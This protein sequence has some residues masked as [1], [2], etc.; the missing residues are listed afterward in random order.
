ME[1][2]RTQTG[3]RFFSIEQED[4]DFDY[5]VISDEYY[6]DR[7]YILFEPGHIHNII[8]PIEEGAKQLSGKVKNPQFLITLIPSKQETKL[9]KYMADNLEG[10]IAANKKS[11]AEQIINYAQ[12][13]SF[14]GFKSAYTYRPKQVMYHMLW[15]DLY[16][17]YLENNNFQNSIQEIKNNKDYYLD[18][19]NQKINFEDIELKF[20]EQINKLSFENK[21][22]EDNKILQTQFQN[23]ILQ[24]LREGGN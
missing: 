15:L 2:Y 22:L 9:E 11:L 4:S 17:D 8:Y 23:D 21:N 6:P 10:I 20:Q 19:R 14:F 3:S 12:D 7:P 16:N 18:I 1:Y 5:W 13:F 24:I